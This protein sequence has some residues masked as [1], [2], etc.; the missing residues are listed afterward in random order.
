MFIWYPSYGRQI[1]TL[2]TLDILDDVEAHLSPFKN[3]SPIIRFGAVW[4]RS[5]R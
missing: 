2:D 4:C 3:P 5:S 1:A